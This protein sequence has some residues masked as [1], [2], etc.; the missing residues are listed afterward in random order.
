MAQ[1]WAIIQ[2]DSVSLVVS[3][4]QFMCKIAPDNTTICS[5]VL[6]HCLYSS[7]SNGRGLCTTRKM[8]LIIFCFILFSSYRDHF[9]YAP[10]QWEMTLHRNVISHWLGALWLLVLCGF[11]L[12]IYPCFLWLLH[13]ITQRQP[14]L[15][16][17]MQK[18]YEQNQLISTMTNNTKQVHHWQ[19]FGWF[20]FL[21]CE[22]CLTLIPWWRHPRETFSTLLAI[23]VG[24]S[25]VTG[26]FPSQRP[27]TRSFDVFFDLRLNK[28]LSKQSW[29]WWFEMPS[30]L[31]W[32]YRNALWCYM[33]SWLWLTLYV[34]NF[35]EET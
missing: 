19:F 22:A 27:V 3:K 21:F 26:E 10:S 4:P 18:Q 35:L 12:F 5:R 9:V 1:C 24:N 20:S 31:L 23:C 15:C 30:R 8:S 7:E 2:C 28:R 14:E 32:Y 13:M 33:A 11:V 29:Y 16:R 25:P 34:L 6:A 17:S